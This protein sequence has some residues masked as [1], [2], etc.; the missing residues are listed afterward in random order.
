MAKQSSV[1]I[2]NNIDLEV[3]RETKKSFQGEGGHHYVEKTIE[4]TYG[5]EGSPSF[6]AEIRSDMSRLTVSSDEPRILGGRGVHVS[7]L[8][9]LLFG[10]MACFANSLAIQCSLNGVKLGRMKVKGRLSYD[11]GP[12]LSEID[13]PL[14]KQLDMEVEA[15]EDVRE[16]IEL[17]KVRCPALYAINHAVRTEVVQAGPPPARRRPRRSGR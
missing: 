17:T 7:P 14:I 3:I 15:D 10:V 9:Y 5:L 13:S 4:G 2:V 8:S 1:T 12:V 11:I 6:A 16:M